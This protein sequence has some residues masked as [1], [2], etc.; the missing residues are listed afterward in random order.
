MFIRNYVIF[1][2]VCYL[3]DGKNL[4]LK[5]NFH[6]VIA[7]FLSDDSRCTISARYWF[8]VL[9]FRFRGRPCP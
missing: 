4:Y 5:N 7:I 9:L 1:G 6:I 8:I 2:R 3:S